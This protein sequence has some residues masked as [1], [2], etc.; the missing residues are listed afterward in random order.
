VQRAPILA[1]LDGAVGLDGACPGAFGVDRAD[2]V[3]RRVVLL[4]SGEVKLD[5]LG[6]LETARADAPGE[7]GGAGK[8]I[9]ALV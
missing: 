5:D 1:A 2:G 8:G 9:D 6:S 3:Q 7:L 4:D